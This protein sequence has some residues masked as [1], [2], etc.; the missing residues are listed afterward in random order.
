MTSYHL[1]N[2]DAFTGR[3]QSSGAAERANYVLFLT[4]FCDVLGV[5]GSWS[6]R[7]SVSRRSWK[8]WP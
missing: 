1:S 4:E 7:L 2:L 8:C 3:W 5:T 6:S